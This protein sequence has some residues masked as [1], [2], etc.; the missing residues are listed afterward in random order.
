MLRIIRCLPPLEGADEDFLAGE[1]ALGEPLSAFG[2]RRRIT[3]EGGNRGV[4]P[5]GGAAVRGY[6]D[7]N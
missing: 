6:G 2:G 5:V 7:L 3:L 4:G 1:L